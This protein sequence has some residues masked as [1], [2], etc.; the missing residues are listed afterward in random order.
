MEKQL[1]FYE[2]LFK[3]NEQA[4]DLKPVSYTHLD[5]YKRQQK[6]LLTQEEADK[7]QTGFTTIDQ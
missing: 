3:D 7:L 4:Y 2:E 5:V 6:E 1:V